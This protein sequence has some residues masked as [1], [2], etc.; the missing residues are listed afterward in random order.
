MRVGIRSAPLGE[1]AMSVSLTR[2]S[3]GLAAQDF[4]GQSDYADLSSGDGIYIVFSTDAANTFLADSNDVSDIWRQDGQSGAL[5]RVSCTLSGA[6]TDGASFSPAIS[7]DGR[8]LAF[9]S[10]ATNLTLNDG[11][12]FADVFR[13]DMA[14]GAVLI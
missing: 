1:D 9:A 8:Y 2:S 7:A 12:G 5:E 4:N 14:T 3:Q 6:A 10:L 13:K 11:N